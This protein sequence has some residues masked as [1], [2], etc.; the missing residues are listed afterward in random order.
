M[1]RFIDGDDGFLA[2]H[3]AVDQ[4]EREGELEGFIGALLRGKPPQ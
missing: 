1:P 4:H 3:A 2:C